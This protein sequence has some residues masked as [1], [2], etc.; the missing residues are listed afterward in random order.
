[1][2]IPSSSAQQVTERELLAAVLDAIAVSPRA[3]QSLHMC[4]RAAT[5]DRHQP[6]LVVGRGDSRQR[7]N[8]RVG[9]LA[10]LQRAA[11]QR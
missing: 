3:Y 9:D 4:R 6:F 8:L 10:A 7:A 1:M 5:G 2:T 11:Q